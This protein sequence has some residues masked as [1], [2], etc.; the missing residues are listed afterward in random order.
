MMNI[1]QTK[2]IGLTMELDLKA[3]EYKILCDELDKLKEKNINPNDERLF[4]VKEL[5][6]QNYNDIAEI[7][8]QI[9]A[10]N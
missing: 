4:V 10:F 5:F 9:K 3:R 1:N 2:L 7:N 8:R 6:L